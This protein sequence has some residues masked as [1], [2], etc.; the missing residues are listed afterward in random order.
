MRFL[1]GYLN[2]V[3]IGHQSTI[4]S[5]FAVG[6][7][8]KYANESGSELEID[9]KILVKLDT[10]YDMS[11]IKLFSTPN[12]GFMMMQIVLE[13]MTGLTMKV[14][15]EQD[16]TE[17]LGMKDTFFNRG[18]VALDTSRIAATELLD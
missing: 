8:V 14:L 15:L 16:L 12:A 7:V 18:S 4:V 13:I 2:C 11:V 6:K 5:H 1:C 17:P 9:K 3:R 10:I